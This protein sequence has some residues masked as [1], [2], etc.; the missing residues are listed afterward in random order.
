MH[1]QTAIS[2]FD[3]SLVE[4]ATVPAALLQDWAQKDLPPTWPDRPGA[5]LRLWWNLIRAPFERG[6][7]RAELPPELTA[8]VPEYAREQFH[9]LPNGYYSH[10][11]AEGYDAGFEAS[12]LF[13]VQSARLRMARAMTRGRVLDAGCG[14]GRLTAALLQ[15]KNDEVWGL[16]PSPYMLKIAQARNPSARFAC[17]LLEQNHFPDEFFDAVGVCFVFHELPR[18]V[19][20]R[21]LSELRRI[22]K[23]GGVVCITEPSREHIDEKNPVVLLRK[24]GIRGLYFHLLA[25]GVYE[26]YLEEWQAIGH[27]GRWLEQAGFELIEQKVEVPFQFLIAKKPNTS[28]LPLK[29]SQTTQ[30]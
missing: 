28:R 26:P 10:S 25:K 4:P 18:Q 9:G 1:V 24:Y 21:A 19:A 11:V 2:E 13:R 3:T 16:D 14:S 7:R 23:P 6:A 30:L 22:V 29:A 15:A 27:H 17:G 5:K 20:E 12:M 8:S